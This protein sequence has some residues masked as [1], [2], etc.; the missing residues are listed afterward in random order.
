VRFEDFQLRKGHTRIGTMIV[1]DL[2][3][4]RMAVK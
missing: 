1:I 3:A 2:G 4:Y